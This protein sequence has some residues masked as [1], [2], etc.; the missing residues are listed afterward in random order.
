MALF[1]F[2]RPRRAASLTCQQG[3][4][5]QG[6]SVTF[7]APAPVRVAFRPRLWRTLHT[8]GIVTPE[9]NAGR[10]VTTTGNRVLRLRATPMPSAHS[11][12][13]FTC[14]IHHPDKLRVTQ[15]SCQ[16]AAVNA[17][18]QPGREALRAASLHAPRARKSAVKRRLLRQP[19]L[20]R[21]VVVT[22]LPCRHRRAPSPF[23][24]PAG[25]SVAVLGQLC[26]AGH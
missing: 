17:L 10:L 5:S 9:V 6:L 24:S 16:A 15:R 4:H 26:C 3:S 7:R 14:R 20:A 12:H 8:R 2:S 13:P 11:A 1:F 18:A 21:W 19:R 25:G 23:I 22:A